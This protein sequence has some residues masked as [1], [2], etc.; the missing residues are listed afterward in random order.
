MENQ[1]D[2]VLEPENKPETKKFT[3]SRAVN[4]V[5]LLISLIFFGYAAYRLVNIPKINVFELTYTLIAVTI[6]VSAAIALGFPHRIKQ[7]LLLTAVTLFVTTLVASIVLSIAGIEPKRAIHQV[8]STVHGKLT[9]PTIVLKS[10]KASD[11]RAVGQVV[12]ALRA[13]GIDAY[14]SPSLRSQIESA[15]TGL[16]PVLPLGGISRVT[17]VNCNEGDQQQFPVLQSDRYGF[18]NEDTVYALN[19]DRILLLGDSFIYGQCVHQEQTIAGHLRRNGY[20]AISLGVGGNGPLFNLAALREYGA[21]L[22]PKTVVWFYTVGNDLVDLRDHEIRSKVLVNYFNPNFSQGLANRQGSVDEVWKTI[23]KNP[24]RWRPIIDD[25]GARA[26]AYRDNGQEEATQ[27]HRRLLSVIGKSDINSVKETKDVVKI[28]GQIL[29]TAKQDVESWGGTLYFAPIWGAPYYRLGRL[30]THID[31]VIAEAKAAKLPF[32]DIDQAIAQSGD[33][34]LFFPTTKDI[35]HHNSKGYALFADAIA[36]VL[37]PKSGLFVLEATFGGNCKDAKLEYPI[38]NIVRPG[39][40]TLA[41]SS[42]CDGKSECDFNIG[43]HLVGSDPAGGCVKDFSA[44]WM[45][46]NSKRSGTL[47]V[48]K[49]ATGVSNVRLSCQDGAPRHEISKRKPTLKPGPG[50]STPSA[51]AKPSS[52]KPFVPKRYTGNVDG[53]PINRFELKYESYVGIKNTVSAD[54]QPQRTE[55][56][57]ILGNSF[58]PQGANTITRVLVKVPVF[59]DRQSKLVVGI[60]VDNAPGAVAHTR[61]SIDAM[62]TDTAIVEYLFQHDGRKSVSV[63]IRIGVGEGGQVHLNGDDTGRSS[64]VPRPSLII[65]EFRPN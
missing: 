22:R 46:I 59:A 2:P 64:T 57:S 33:H 32:I 36:G 4:F 14:R 17:T 23:W 10:R 43:N 35:P 45:C 52:S 3:S 48:D 16:I 18:N 49:N 38:A 53:K 47:Y 7:N 28:I 19:S 61:H 58:V 29:R 8:I 30:P 26:T 41:I 6:A 51:K 56:A 21:Q 39:N 9:P 42:R 1:S 54:G 11:N 15:D 40:A 31:A 44:A 37:A 34:D 24:T 50:Q 55:T 13:N 12:E 5:I 62:N 60:F 27:V 63:D 20:A 65:E 25:H